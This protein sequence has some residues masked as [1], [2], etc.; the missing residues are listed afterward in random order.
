MKP[1]LFS[2]PDKAML[3]VDLG[4][5]KTAVGLV[6]PTG[7]LLSVLQEPTLQKGPQM[8]IEHICRMLEGIIAQIALTPQDVLGIGIGIPAVLETASDFVIWAP[9]LQ[10]WRNVALK[11]AVETR[12]HLPVCVEYD[13]HTAALGEWWQGNNRGCCSLVNI[14]IGTGVGGGMILDGKLF[15]GASRLAGAVGWFA[16]GTD[17]E[18]VD[19]EKER[20]L[21][22]WE[23]RI[24][25]PAIARRALYYLENREFP[26]STLGKQI[27]D[28]TAQ[29]VFFAAQQGDAL[30]LRVVHEVADWIGMGVANIVSLAN[31]DVVVF[32]GGVGAHLA[33]LL[34]QIKSVVEHYAQPI[35]ARK[36][37]ITVSS[38]GN[39]AGLLGAA[40]ALWLRLQEE[41][42]TYL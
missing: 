5:T 39:K 40:Y 10:G 12:F 27:G 35:S 36:V 31:P 23:A 19:T 2:Q 38:L 16:L 29:E 7:Q 9:N 15:R 6:S 14:I 32:G 17:D 21:G 18:R 41:G 25:G 30:A 11:E 33:F 8:G 1:V 3:A 37:E 24:A 34:P 26:P 22:A 42:Q 4:G 28:L 20:S 13:G